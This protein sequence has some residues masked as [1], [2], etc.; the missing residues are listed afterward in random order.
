MKWIKNGLIYCPEGQYYWNKTHAQIPLSFI[1]DD[2]TLR[3][4]YSSRDEYNRSN[5][6][7]IE[8]EINNPSV[9]K[10]IHNKPLLNFGHL[11]EFDDSGIMPS[12]IVRM[13]GKTYLYYTGWNV[14]VNIHYI[15][16]IGLAIS[17]DNGRTFTKFSNGPILDRSVYDPCLCASPA[18]ILESKILRMWYISGTKWEIINNRPE[19]FYHIK[20]WIREGKVCIDYDSFTEGISRPSILKRGE[21]YFLFYSYRNNLNYRANKENGYRIGFAISDDGLKWERKDKEIGIYFSNGGWDSEM[22]AYPNVLPHKD[23]LYMFY[24]GN[25]FGRTGFGYAVLEE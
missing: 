14:G 20:Y 11:G 24:N 4:Y 23:Q 13:D 25:G 10:Y 22:M 7:Y 5:L 18:I 2:D 15:L 1:V 19:P 12:C 17:E 6:S 21:K 8:V 3:I 16:A 9:I